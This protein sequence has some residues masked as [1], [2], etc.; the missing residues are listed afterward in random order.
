MGNTINTRLTCQ[1]PSAPS[2]SLTEYPGGRGINLIRDN[3]LTT[4]DN[5]LTVSPSSAAQQTFTDQLTYNDIQSTD[6]TIWFRGFFAPGKSSNY[7]FQFDSLTNGDSVL[8]LSTNASSANKVL[9][10]FE[11][12]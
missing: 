9:N 2:S 7:E 10:F 12:F 5:L 11:I 6:V 4:F 1:T 8:L 3:F